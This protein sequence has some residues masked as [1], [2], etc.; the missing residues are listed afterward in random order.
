MENSVSDQVVL[1][2]REQVYRET[3]EE[4]KKEFPQDDLRARL[5]GRLKR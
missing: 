1:Q 4:L 5:L 2:E 3:T